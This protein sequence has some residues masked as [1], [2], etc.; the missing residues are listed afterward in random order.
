MERKFKITNIKKSSSEG[1]DPYRDERGLVLQR[2][3]NEHTEILSGT[4]PGQWNYDCSPDDEFY[5]HF[6]LMEIISIEG[7]S[8][9]LAFSSS[10]TGRPCI[11]ERL[12]MAI[13]YEDELR[14]AF[15]QWGEDRTLTII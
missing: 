14:D 4:L 3:D 15:R 13:F 5:E 1:D 2:H 7:R 11:Y 10:R 6:L 9:S 8:F 12:G